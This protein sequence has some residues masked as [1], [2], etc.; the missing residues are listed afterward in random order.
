[1][2]NCYSYICVSI[3]FY[4]SFPC[5]SIYY[6]YF[7]L[8][9]SNSDTWSFFSFCLT[10]LTLFSSYFFS[11]VPC[12]FWYSARLISRS[13]YMSTISKF[14]L[15][16]FDFIQS[17]SSSL[18]FC[19]FYSRLAGG[20]GLLVNRCGTLS[21]NSAIC[22]GGSFSNL[23]WFSS[24]CASYTWSSGSLIYFSIIKYK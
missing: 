21:N 8:I 14:S 1:M 17:G 2:N 24:D 3:C 7:C 12:F 10:S 11:K 15:K 22:L 13:V 5:S 20:C 19:L 23:K 18:S 16:S 9:I 6:L 4:F